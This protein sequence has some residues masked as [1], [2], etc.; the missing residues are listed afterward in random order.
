MAENNGMEIEDTYRN[1]NG[2][3][4]QMQSMES[5][6]LGTTT[7]K[8]ATR[9]FEEIVGIYH[10]DKTRYEAILKEAKAMIDKN[11]SIVD[12]FSD[13]LSSRVSPSKLSEYF[14]YC[15]DM[16]KF[17]LEHH[18]ILKPLL[19]ITDIPT[20]KKAL[21]AIEQNRVFRLEHKKT[22]TKIIAAGKSYL[23]FLKERTAETTAAAE[24]ALLV[25][26][27][28]GI[29]EKAISA[30]A[31]P[32]QK[33]E[34]SDRYA[35]I[36]LDEF[37][38]GLRQNVI[39]IKK[40]IT[41]YTERYGS[42]PETD[43]D[44][45]LVQLKAVGIVLDDRIYAR[46]SD[47]ARNGL[48]EKIWGDVQLAFENGASCVFTEML[49]SRF[50]YELAQELNIFHKD[51]MVAALPEN[52]NSSFYS[53]DGMILKKGLNA[54]YKTD[55]LRVL[56]ASHTPLTYADLQ[57]F[58]W[59]IPFDKI[60]QSLVGNPK[61]VNVD[62]ETYFFAPNLPISTEE[63]ERLIRAMNI[64]IE[65]RGFLVAQDLR[66]LLNSYCP[67]AAIDTADMKDYGL[68]NTL[69]YLLRDR[70]TFSGALIT[71]H[72][73]CMSISDAYHSFCR[74]R[75]SLSLSELKDFANSLGVVIYWS[76]ILQEMVRISPTSLIRKDCVHFQVEATDELL[77]LYCPGDYIPI[78]DVELFLQFPSTGVPWNTFVLESYVMQ[79]SRKFRMA[80]A[81]ISQSGVYGAIVRKNSPLQDYHDVIVDMLARTNGWN[82]EAS[83]LSLVVEKGY[84]ERKR[85]SGFDKVIKET[86]LLRE[87]IN[88]KER[89]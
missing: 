29:T 17:C 4:F 42:E 35:S 20:I 10:T 54:D 85:W 47:D 58:L 2:I 28:P 78:G 6:Y 82:D 36:L 51:A 25:S 49:F 5:A 26:N 68:R 27:E 77:E 81:S 8:P 84:Q 21:Q 63:M 37:P 56:R 89:G 1:V 46:K 3:S 24:N 75:E 73:M 66:K 70:F 15:R 76:D 71:S 61:L 67:S 9:L 7:V 50:S 12:S 86:L 83:A 65:Q 40:F 62:M 87:Q 44:T 31:L 16:E 45:L 11:E 22:H 13:Y 52:G 23:N 64:E 69:S 53:A 60:K 80:Q 39:H 30:T 72:G 38:D 41:R 43:R 32:K 79:A 59:Y 14:L 19:E 48:I 34:E 55:V 74:E 57:N 88:G 33:Q 18:I